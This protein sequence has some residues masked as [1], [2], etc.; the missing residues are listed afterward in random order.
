MENMFINRLVCNLRYLFGGPSF[1]WKVIT[2]S[3]AFLGTITTLFGILNTLYQDN[4]HFELMVKYFWLFILFSVLL[5][6][7]LSL[8]YSFSKTFKIEGSDA[9]IT[10]KIGNIVKENKSPVR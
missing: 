5:S 8:N 2:K 7:T 6:S 1:I 4:F 10:I 3:V 9:K